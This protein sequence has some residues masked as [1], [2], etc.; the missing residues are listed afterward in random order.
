MA[1]DAFRFAESFAVPA[2][3]MLT[4]QKISKCTLAQSSYD[5]WDTEDD[6]MEGEY[7]DSMPV[8]D[9]MRVKAMRILLEQSWNSKDMGTVPTS[10]EKAAEAAAESVASAMAKSHNVMMID[11]SLP[12]YDITEG[13]RFY[14]RKAVY[15][16]CT[17]LTT[18]L[19]ER[20][21]ITKSLI[22]VR[23]EE[24]RRLTE[25]ACE[26]TVVEKPGGGIEYND[27]EEDTEEVSDFREQLIRSW[28]S[29]ASV[30]SNERKQ[31]SC[32]DDASHRLWSMVGD[33][34]ISSG[35]DMFDEVI[36]AVDKHA[37]LEVQYQ[38]DAI[39]VVTPYDTVDTI[40]VRRILARYGQTRTI[41]FLNSR[42]QTLPL[43]M[44]DA[45]FVYGVMPLIARKSSKSYDTDPGPKVVVMKRFPSEWQLFIDLNGDGFVKANDR[46]GLPTDQ[47][48]YPPPE[49]IARNVQYHVEGLS[50]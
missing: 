26:K 23:N 36:A 28:E 1:A 46:L 10:P 35:S 19:R 40:A 18:Q 21:L 14:D 38:E 24:E 29:S 50:Q 4:Q 3:P 20:K 8:T 49:W 13:S 33:E 45:V 22:L 30:E 6:D 11:L 16:F 32:T 15:D 17:Y 43:E 9:D 5:D 42:M 2:A 34:A 39:I 12:S 31:L 7:E 48:D 37:R 44:N 47:K 41:I 27:F 25:R